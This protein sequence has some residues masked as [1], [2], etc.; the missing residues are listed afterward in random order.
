[1]P[2]SI[3]LS[4]KLVVCLIFNHIFVLEYNYC[5]LYENIIII[6]FDIFRKIYNFFN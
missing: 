4:I 5:I 3:E 1:M 2:A 6:K